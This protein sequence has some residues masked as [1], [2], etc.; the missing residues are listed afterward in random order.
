M[1][2][3]AKG[4]LTPAMYARTDTAGYQ[5]ALRKAKNMNVL[6]QGGVQNRPGT[7]FVSTV[8]DSSKR[9]RLI[10]F[11]FGTDQ[12][13]VLEFGNGYMRVYKN[14]LKVRVE[15]GNPDVVSVTLPN[16]VEVTGHGLANGTTISFTGM[17]VSIPALAPEVEFLVDNANVNDFEITYPDGSPVNMVPTGFPY[18]GGGLVLIPYEIVSPY[19]EAQIP[20]IQFVQS[21]N[22]LYMVQK[23]HPPQKLTRNADDD[24]EF[25]E[26]LFTP[27]SPAPTAMSLHYYTAF[28]STV[29]ATFPALPAVPGNTG[30]YAGQPLATPGS[31]YTQFPADANFAEPEYIVTA[32]DQDSGIESQPAPG[33]RGFFF[34]F[35]SPPS[36]QS[37][38]SSNVQ[39]R[40]II[41]TTSAN[42]MVATISNPVLLQ[43]DYRDDDI[44]RITGTG[45]TQLD[46]KVFKINVISPTQIEFPDI[47]ATAL[48]SLAGLMVGLI[49]RGNTLVLA[50]AYDE[51]FYGAPGYFSRGPLHVQWGAPAVA[52]NYVYNLYKRASNGDFGLLA[53]TTDLIFGDTGLVEPDTTKQ[54]KEYINFTGGSNWPSVIGAYQQRLL[55]ANTTDKPETI[56]ASAIGDF[57]EFSPRPNSAADDEPFNF[58]IYGRDANPVRHLI[59][60]GSLVVLTD[61]GEW[62]IQGGASG[63]LTPTE[64]NA[65]QQGYYGSSKLTP[66][67]VGRNLIFLQARQSKIRELF[68]D[69]TV[70][71]FRGGDLSI[72]S[73]HLFDGFTFVDMCYK[74][75]PSSQ[76]WMARSDGKFL[77]MTYIPEEQMVAWTPHETDGEIEALCSVPEGIEDVV[78]AIVRRNISGI[79]WRFIE[80]MSSRF[81]S[82]IVQSNFM[83][84]TL[85]YDGRN[86]R[87]IVFAVGG[88]PTNSFPVLLTANGPTP[89]LFTPGMVGDAIIFT[90]TTGK[91]IRFVLE[92]YFDSQQMNA[93]A[94]RS[95]TAEE[96]AEIIAGEAT[97]AL[98]VDEVHGLWH[99]EGKE[100]S[101]YADGA[102]VHSASEGYV[103]V[104]DGSITLNKQ[105]AYIRVGLPYFSDVETLDIDSGAPGSTGADKLMFTSK[106]SLQVLE[107]RGVYAGTVEPTGDDPLQNLTE[108]P[109]RL[110]QDFGST[111]DLKTGIMMKA[112]DARWAFGG[113]VFIRQVDPLPMT[114]LSIIPAGLFPVGG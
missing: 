6:R 83:D 48:P 88:T 28:P 91:T 12:T 105:Y 26:L 98:A 89:Q 93:R 13:Y 36:Y 8:K 1:L 52:G 39:Q 46:G 33:C 108:F 4:E 82:D 109:G 30:A 7:V 50:A 80:R 67:V 2:N 25:S 40:S 49:T 10:P 102:V 15:I 103:T 11:V 114:I 43:A 47:D 56:W 55:L 16:I 84:S 59:D 72:Y 77:S 95:T 101:V 65:R 27:D 23:G 21:R 19:T 44:V 20:D 22:V 104:V 113:R 74:Q 112:V 110:A 64:I 92:E 86:T 29:V 5:A 38:Y 76:V 106:L 61:R 41:S 69:F 68:P 54:P 71:G 58:Q 45:N 99:L 42:P 9:T 96:L 85:F 81:I 35:A 17:E 37:I 32:V 31:E 60:L 70:S 97:W 78:Y 111:P 18:T 73:N 94:E 57:E 90:F 79:Q 53:S 51:P 100:V 87:D 24:W 63:A 62:N 14:G 34:G 75:E 107:T 3:F 66:I